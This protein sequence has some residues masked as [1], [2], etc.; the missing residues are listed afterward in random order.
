MRRGRAK[1]VTAPAT[2]LI[3]TAD[4]KSHLREDSSANDVYIDELVLAATTMLETEIERQLITATWEYYLDSFPSIIQLPYG[5]VQTV[6]SIKYWNDSGEQTL[7]AAD[8]DVGEEGNITRIISK[9]TG[10]PTTDEDKLN[11]VIVNYDSGYGAASAVPADIKSAVKLILGDLYTNR[12]DFALK[13]GY[14][15]R[16]INLYKNWYS[17]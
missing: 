16:V 1:Q 6:N 14:V 7:D 13:R 11:A 5:P 8:Y 10:W 3:S 17:D 4:A 12:E 2:V 15:Q 9:N